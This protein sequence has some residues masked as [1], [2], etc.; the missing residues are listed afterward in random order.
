MRLEA[1]TRNIDAI[2]KYLIVEGDEL[3]DKIDR[4]LAK[5]DELGKYWKG[6]DYDNFREAYRVYLMNMKT[7]Y[8]KLNAFGNAL[9]GVSRYYSD[10]NETFGSKMRKIGDECVRDLRREQHRVS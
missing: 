10:V 9:K 3:N 7:S 8:I 6:P 4:M 5:V 1:K 2:G